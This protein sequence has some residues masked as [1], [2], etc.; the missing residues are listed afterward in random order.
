MREEGTVTPCL[1]GAAVSG[2]HDRWSPPV[3]PLLEVGGGG[4]RIF[5]MFPLKIGLSFGISLGP[6]GFVF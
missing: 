3:S 6:I 5:F 4:A 2:P 1:G